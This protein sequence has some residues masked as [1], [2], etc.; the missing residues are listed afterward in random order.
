MALIYTVMLLGAV[1]GGFAV[2]LATKGALDSSR[3]KKSAKEL[4]GQLSDDELQEELVEREYKRLP[5]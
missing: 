4:L 3:N 1:L 2:G 5:A